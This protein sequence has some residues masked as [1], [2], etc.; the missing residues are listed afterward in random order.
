MPDV[1]AP[2]SQWWFR[3]AGT[4][5][6]YGPVSPEVL[7]GWA[8]EGRVYPEDKVSPDNSSWGDARGLPFLAMDTVIVRPDGRVLGPYHRNAVEALRKV[9]KVPPESV[10]RSARELLAAADSA[11][12]PA[13]GADAAKAYEARLEQVRTQARDALAEK[14]R[15]LEGSRA[16]ADRLG[17]ELEAERK[18][19]AALRDAAAKAEAARAE[20]ERAAAAAREG[21][22]AQA[23]ASAE[24]SSL[25]EALRAARDDAAAARAAAAN[26]ESARA[27]AEA[28]AATAKEEA[29][30]RA[31]AAKEE[32]AAAEERAAGRIEEARKTA[33]DEAARTVAEAAE[34]AAAEAAAAAEAHEAELEA[35][36]AEAAERVAAADS[37]RARAAE[38]AAA[39]VEAAREDAARA[40]AEAAAKEEQAAKA[41]ADLEA[42]RDENAELL[43]FSNT[44]DVEAK[45]R[46]EA[47]EARLRAL[48]D[49]PSVGIGPAVDL[50]ET[51][52]RLDALQARVTDLTRERGELAEKL[53]A[54]EAGL[55][56]AKRPLEGDIAV[57]R[58]FAD[59]ALGA[60]RDELQEEKRRAEAARA[61][62]AARQDALRERI[63]ALERSLRRDPGEKSRSELAV[64]R[65]EKTI[66]QLRQQ[67][68][69]ERE[70]H[71]A[72]IGRAGET[73][74]ALEGRIRALQQRESSVREQLLRVEKRTAD[75][76][77][78]TS[79]LRRRE[80][81]AIERAKELAEA[82]EQWQVVQTALQRRI[83]ELEH[84]AGS[85]FDEASAGASGGA[86]AGD[87]PSGAR[88]FALPVWA[89][90]MK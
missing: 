86:P 89:Q 23:A 52:H 50:E 48:P 30:A 33:A 73:E 14:D 84:G 47:L 24:L 81:E 39:R 16:E 83:D 57:A 79:Q 40:A 20:A 38:E 32:A 69:S 35:V 56:V 65:N 67:L 15:E 76:D 6:V 61:A 66:A 72:D 22:A 90:K 88:K 58:Q 60:L 34:K 41:A 71:R 78:L 75:Y 7:L 12:A 53:A 1:S 51:L 19:A 29:E 45:A 49:D 3:A 74:K 63:G 18:A 31:A 44:R 9:G 36:R 70:Q 5:K 37:D 17:E 8:R 2:S 4:E 87:G 25:R 10:V 55:A 42:L 64:E 80:Q 82:R 27:A 28:A 46:I 26:A 85:L 54:A 59:E 62:S 77:S 43:A 68:D 21:A 13:A 11:A